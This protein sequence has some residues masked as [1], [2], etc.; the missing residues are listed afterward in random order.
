MPSHDPSLDTNPPLALSAAELKILDLLDVKVYVKDLNSRFTYMNSRCLQNMRVNSLAE[1][2]GKT[3]ADFFTADLAAQQRQ[4]EIDVMTTG[5]PKDKLECEQWG[6]KRQTWV[7]TSKVPLRG[8]DGTIIGVVGTSKDVTDFE[9]K[10]LAYE[11]LLDQIPDPMW[12]KNADLKFV[13]VNAALAK[14][15]GK[16]KKEIHNKTDQDHLTIQQEIDQFRRDDLAVLSTGKT[17]RKI[18]KITT[19]DSQV[20]TIETQKVRLPGPDAPAE[21]KYQVLGIA[22]DVTEQIRAQRALQDERQAR[23]IAH[24]LNGWIAVMEGSWFCL[25]LT[26]G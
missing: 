9:N 3:D 25:K 13:F 21:S 1:V 14:L 20:R 2:I 5:K 19:R 4:D 8:P 10:A 16:E 6:D 22:R 7:L 17:L 26:H 24:A 12:V 11:F 18:E 15:L 23:T